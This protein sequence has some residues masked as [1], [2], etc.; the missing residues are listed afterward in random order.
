VLVYL[1]GEIRA[2]H[3]CRID[4]F[5][6]GFLL[7]DGLYE[8]LRAFDGC[9]VAPELHAERLR[10]GL[11]AVGIS[12][13]AG[14]LAG[15][16]HSLLDANGLR[17][18]FIYVQV[19]RGAPGPGQPVRS[20]LPAGAMTP[21]V[22]GFAAAAAALGS[23]P[24]V[25]VKSAITMTD[26]R[27]LRGEVK[28]ISLMGGVLAAL[29]S[30]GADADDAILIRGRAC[31]ERRVAESTS[32]NAILV[33]ERGGRRE[34]VT[35]SLESAPIL[36]GVTR[37]VLVRGVAGTELEMVERVVLEHELAAAREVLL[38]GTLTMV[39]AV[40]AINGRRV[41]D[42][43]AGPVAHALLAALTK[44]IACHGAAAAADPCRNG[45]DAR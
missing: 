27:W 36:A 43:K 38:C 7:G 45:S 21:T 19:T 35:P 2:R 28:S 42:G 26:P 40:T 9:V 34:I 6:R 4:P 12:W 20:R 15:V 32:A 14:L 5:D 16:C 39:T 33:L 11:A 10:Q 25:P 24:P 3:E 37:D 30:A 31:G 1:N 29:E 13:D 44:M 22:F 18:A 17:D 8:G 41:G 23:Y